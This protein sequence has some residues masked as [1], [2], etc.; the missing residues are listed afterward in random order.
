MK[1]N[2]EFAQAPV[3]VSMPFVVETVSGQ[4]RSYDLA[5]KMMQNRLIVIDSDFNDQMAHVIK[6]QLLYLDSVSSEPVTLYITSPGGSVH[7][8]LGIADVVANMRAPVTTV[9]I[10]YAAS[11]GC[12]TQSVLGTPGRRFAGA[13]AFIMCHQV[14]SGTQGL[15][16]D[17]K[18]SLKH[19]E[20]LNTLLTSEIAE[21][22]GVS[23]EQLLAD[24]DRD[25]WLNAEE[26]LNYGEKGFI[27]GIW[28]G[29][30]NDQGQYLVK[31]RGGVEE[32]V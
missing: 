15:I 18:I 29:K 9:V 24:A 12:Y 1:T 5:S 4:E 10:G 11:M 23:H 3:A 22:V 19:S 31:R 2:V 25:L 13:R 16:T 27:D 6:L 20:R 17:Q 7:A 30:R 32:W 28:L 21:A 26:A 14:S 8:G